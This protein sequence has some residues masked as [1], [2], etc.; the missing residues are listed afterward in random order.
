MVLVCLAVVLAIGFRRF[1]LQSKRCADL[2]QELRAAQTRLE[3]FSSQLPV[4]VFQFV[5]RPK[6]AA[7][8]YFDYVSDG[9][10][11]LLPVTA[12][13]LRSDASL[14]LT[15]IIEEDKS[16]LL[17]LLGHPV[18]SAQL[19]WEGRVATGD[20]TSRWLSLRAAVNVGSG[21]MGSLTGVLIDI[22]PFKNAQDALANS[23][24]SIRQLAAHRESE[25]EREYRSLAREFHDE[26]GQ[27]LTSSRLHLQAIERLPGT[28][29][30]TVVKEVDAMLTDAYRSM[31]SIT[32]ELRPPALNLGL[33]AA[34]E[35]QADRALRPQKIRFTSAFD[36]GLSSLSESVR[37]TLFRI[38][39]EAFTNV[40][41]YA[42]ATSVHVS[43]RCDSAHLHLTISDDGCGFSPEAVD[44]RLHFGL[45][46]MSE[47][48]LALGGELDID[49]APGEGAR[50][51][52]VVPTTAGELV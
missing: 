21:G 8:G 46:G 39:Q 29:T 27:V 23:R 15:H 52:C 36:P 12:E 28:A 11:D 26:L 38:V 4:A 44:S 9:I 45:V 40:I 37:T 5:L 32:T 18:S 25:R 50:I 20:S 1:R 51:H 49:S 17:W 6:D 43:A 48:A 3:Q 16:G 47:R 24:E 2:V 10:A 42:N 22:T 31:K 14:L 41:R 34:I 33:A 19:V 7:G 30:D 13:Q 35:W